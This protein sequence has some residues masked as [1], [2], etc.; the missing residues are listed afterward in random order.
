MN[1]TLSEDAARLVAELA[2]LV[3]RAPNK[4]KARTVTTLLRAGGRPAGWL[5][6]ILLDELVAIG[7][8][9]VSAG[10]ACTLTPAGVEIARW[11]EAETRARFPLTPPSLLTVT[12]ARVLLSEV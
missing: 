6:D 8:V 11:L 12:M 4:T 9:L 7:L 3:R 1:A 2:A 5:Q 10:R